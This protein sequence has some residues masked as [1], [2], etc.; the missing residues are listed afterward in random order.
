MKSH[1][2]DFTVLKISCRGTYYGVEVPLEVIN[3]FLDPA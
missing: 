2:L 1:I 3:E